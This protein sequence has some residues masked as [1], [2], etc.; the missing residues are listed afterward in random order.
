MKK[1]VKVFGQIKFVASS[2][3]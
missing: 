1:V 3:M 2:I